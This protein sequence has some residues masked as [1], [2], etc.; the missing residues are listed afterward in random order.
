[1]QHLFKVAGTIPI[2][3]HVRKYDSTLFCH[4]NF[5]RTSTIH[6]FSHVRFW[7][8][9]RVASNSTF[10]RHPPLVLCHLLLLRTAGQVKRLECLWSVTVHP[11]GD[12]T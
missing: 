7:K 3:Y 1:M 11:P 12:R 8:A 6:V 5:T 4:N 10:P 2:P 9:F